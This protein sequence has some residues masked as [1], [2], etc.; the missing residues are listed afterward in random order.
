MDNNMNLLIGLLFF[1]ISSA[2]IFSPLH[3]FISMKFIPIV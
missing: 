2:I 3:V 1:Q